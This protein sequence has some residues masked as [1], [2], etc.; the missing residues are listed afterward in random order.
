VIQEDPSNNT[1]SDSEQRTGSALPEGVE[2]SPPKPEVAPPQPP[3]P[4]T[5]SP[6]NLDC[7]SGEKKKNHNGNSPKEIFVTVKKDAELSRFE[8]YTL[9][10]SWFSLIVLI[11]TFIV[12][13]LQLRE[14][15][16]QTG[17]FRDQANQAVT[18]AKLTRD[19]TDRQIQVVKDQ[20]I[21]DERPYIWLQDAPNNSIPMFVKNA[22]SGIFSWNV[23][24]TNY[25]KSPAINL[26]EEMHIEIG[27][28]ALSKVID[29]S[30]NSCGSIHAG[31][32]PPSR[33]EWSTATT[34]RRVSDTEIKDWFALEYGVVVYGRFDYT[35]SFG[36]PYFSQFCMARQ[37]NGAIANCQQHNHIY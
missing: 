8:L 34:E 10:L 18:D 11:F 13:A 1:K 30:H 22:E 37:K 3:K 5:V 23:F 27:K 17:I 32:L 26:C 35:D 16:T 31:I 9:G 33:L 12:F 19:Q 36:K 28:K 29:I 15:K 6:E 25:G 7:D 21:A 20:F 4:P 24:Y 14:S 2:P